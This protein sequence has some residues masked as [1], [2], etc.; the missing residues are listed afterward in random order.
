[1]GSGGLGD[2]QLFRGGRF[3]PC[4]GST[5]VLDGVDHQDLFKVLQPKLFPVNEKL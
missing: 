1:M 3:L 4:F 2:D 5:V